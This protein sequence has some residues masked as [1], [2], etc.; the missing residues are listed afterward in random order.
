MLTISLDEQG[1]FE[2]SGIDSPKNREPLLI[3]GFIFDDMDLPEECDL[4]KKRIYYYLKS[5][6]CQTQTRYPQDLH[7]DGTNSDSVRVVKQ[8]ISQTLNEFL[9][10]GVCSFEGNKYAG[11]L[12]KMPERKGKYYIFAYLS[13][14]TT[15]KPLDSKAASILIRNGYA[16][17]LYLHMAEEVVDRM[18]FYNPVIDKV[19]KVRLDLATRMVVI[20]AKDGYDHFEEY[21]SLGYREDSKPEHKEAG[22]KKIPLTNAD[23]YRT[24]VEREMRH[25]GKDGISLDRLYVRSIYY[26][27]ESQDY[28]ME[29]LYMADIICSVLG[30]RPVLSSPEALIAD[31]KNRADRCSGH[32]D[33]LIFAY[34]ETD[35][36]FKKAWVK[37]EEKEYF[38]AL[39]LV[40]QGE[41]SGSPYAGFYTEIWFPRIREKLVSEKDVSAF[42]IAVRKFYL[43]TRDNSL[44]QDEL[45]DIYGSLEAMKDHLAFRSAEDKASLYELY[46]AGVSAFCHIGDSR[47]AEACFEQCREYAKYVEIE[48]YLRTRNKMVVYLTDDFAFGRALEIAQE[49]ILLHEEILSVRE[50]IFDKQEVSKEYGI[51]LSQLGQ[52]YTSCQMSEAE[53]AFLDALSHMGENTPDYF[54]TASYLLHYY[55]QTGELEK[56]DA[57]AEQYFGGNKK[58]KDQLT[59][60]IREGK[61]GAEARFS[62]K[63]A[64]YVFVKGLYCFHLSDIRDALGKR[65]CNIEENIKSI[66]GESAA[67]QIN[68]HPWEIIYKYLA[69]IALHLGKKEKADE[70]MKKSKDILKYH[71]FTLDGI[72]LFGELEYAMAKGDREDAE[73][74]MKKIAELFH[75]NHPDIYQNIKIGGPDHTYRYLKKNVMNFMYS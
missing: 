4:E 18:I 32:T 42:S 61:K 69:L 14:G 8:M 38:D 37:L 5:V 15:Q 10:K 39:R 28:R 64:L 75:E 55:L 67:G 44:K 56:Y 22:K 6:C 23:V 41:N 13:Y 68:N 7:A 36:I 52:V 59:Y 65:L 74:Q 58:L 34:D 19:S 27:N 35:M 24:A 70:Y 29:F 11:R 1:K 73:D 63:F 30:Y 16:S 51:A 71:G 48:R 43:F 49:D 45:V 50:L 33:N 46:D 2:Q 25:T 54:Q 17:N 26:G 20:D 3:G 53:Q 40:Y 62:M 57:L 47:K 21:L 72:C 12:N 60:L 66:G 31:L 9:R